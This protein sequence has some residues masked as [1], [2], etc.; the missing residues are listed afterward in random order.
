MD[1][2]VRRQKPRKIHCNASEQISSLI[3]IESGKVSGY[4]PWAREWGMRR[5]NSFH[6]KL[7]V[8]SAAKLFLSQAQTGGV[9]Q[10]NRLTHHLNIC[11]FQIAHHLVLM[12]S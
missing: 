5:I 10:L 7:E 1:S 11:K 6:G 9:A 2:F 12:Q 4:G 8:K 3:R